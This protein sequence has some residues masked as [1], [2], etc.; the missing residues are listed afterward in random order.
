[1]KNAIHEL[2]QDRCTGCGACYN[3]CPQNAIE[4]K[5]NGEGFLFPDI[6]V[7]KCISCGL[8]KKVCPE[9]NSAKFGASDPECYA[10]WAKD[11]VRWVTSSGG[12]FVLCADWILEQGGY[13]CGAEFTKD[14][15]G[16]K[17]TIIDHWT[18]LPNLMRSKYLQSDINTVYMQI[19]NL[20]DTTNKPVLFCGCPCQV[21]GLLNM[22]GSGHD[23]LYTLDLVCHGVPS[24]KAYRMYLDE[25]AN[26]K[27]IKSVNFRPKEKGWGTPFQIKYIDGKE[28]YED[29]K[30]PYYTAFLGGFSDRESCYSCQYAKIPR[31][32][33]ITIADFWGVGKLN[34]SWNDNKGTSLVIVND[35][36]GKMLFNSVKERMTLC[37]KVK[38]ADLKEIASTRNGNLI[39]PIK[40]ASAR[41][42]FFSHLNKHG[43][44]K[45][46]RYA[47][48]EIF[49]IGIVGWW[50]GVN[51]GST[52]TSYALYKFLN[53]Q[54]LSVLMI[55]PSS[56][57]KPEDHTS[58][59]SEFAKKR[60]RFSVP[61]YDFEMI[62]LNNYC[63]AFIV[64]SDQLW[65]YPSFIKNG[66]L[67]LL[68]FV[69]EQKKKISYATSFGHEK[70][71]FPDTEL[72]KARFYMN[73][74]DYISVRESSG[75]KIIYDNFGM[76][77]V[78]MP[79]P[80]FL[81]N[82][83]EYKNLAKESK[84][85]IASSQIFSYI[86]DPTNEKKSMLHFLEENLQKSSIVMT[87]P[88]GE[89]QK[90]MEKLSEFTILQG[91]I[92]DWIC[93]IM[94]CS[95]V[96]TDSF[97]GM[98]FSLMFEKPFIAIN[99]TIRGSERF[100]SL[101]EQ[102]GLKDRLVNSLNDIKTHPNLLNSFDY[103]KIRIFI[104][105]ERKRGSQWLMNAINSHKDTVLSSYDML[106]RENESLKKRITILEQKVNKL[107]S[108]LSRDEKN[109]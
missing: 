85:K 26:G 23:R 95:F 90:R 61:R 10:V 6:V 25:V 3:I 32:G 53:T 70:S 89:Y 7:E 78:Q 91:G 39:R 45:A 60:Y 65:N 38:I 71:F 74:F 63:D 35:D 1:M 80:I 107:I 64:G 88:Q 42:I 93:N 50:N 56:S 106:K 72:S 9:I 12:M 14:F 73:R 84:Q 52:L 22:L 58:G 20:L 96:L 108:N 33:N 5:E 30:G 2:E 49:D 47:K 54:N 31:I 103:T 57:V 55:R 92:E 77:A 11:T 67:F 43:F 66:Y 8:C 34:S 41:N 44:A 24:P 86:L 104:E 28:H 97:H 69:D 105:N 48:K 37:E 101:L 83:D 13:V 51:Y 94:N 99:N 75:E 4:M 79:D 98:C 68:N 109:I 82:L 19:K 59:I 16:V 27:Q 62:D 81:L 40:K 46:L 29:F 102:L 36:K 18:K 17:H 100:I 87:D 15:R 21:A 76:K